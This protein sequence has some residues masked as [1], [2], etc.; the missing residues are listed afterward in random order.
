MGLLNELKNLIVEK[1]TKWYDVALASTEMDDI[2]D[3][4]R[5]NFANNHEA[6]FNMLERKG[7]G[8]KFL[9]QLA[10]NWDD[11]DTD[12]RILQFLGGPKAYRNGSIDNDLFD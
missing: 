1:P 6:M 10:F 2:F 4:L 7:L 8:R 3:I 11:V 5:I 9:E 12:L